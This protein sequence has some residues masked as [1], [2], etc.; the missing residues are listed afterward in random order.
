MV[1]VLASP[2]FVFRVEANRARCGQ[3]APEVLPVDEYTLASPALY[4]LWSTMPD[5]ELFPRPNEAS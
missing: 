1:A 3:S 5:E 4:F 2:R